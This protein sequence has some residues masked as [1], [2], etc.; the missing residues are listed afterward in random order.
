MP[1]LLAVVEQHAHQAAMLWLCR[2]RAIGEPHYSLAG[3]AKLDG[4]LDAH[5]DG[6]RIA[7]EAGWE[8]AEHELRW[9]EPGEVFA[10]ALLAFESGDPQRVQRVLSVA[11]AS[12]ELSCALVSALGWLP[13]DN[14]SDF[15][16]RFL[17][18]DDPLLR[19]VGVAASALH[20]SDPGPTLVEAI[21]DRDE[22][23]RARALR[24]AGE[25]GRVDLLSTL[26]EHLAEETVGCRFAAAWSVAL[27]A[28]EV[29]AVGALRRLVEDG[30]EKTLAAL[31]LA[32]RRT[33]IQE[34]AI[35]LPKLAAH[36]IGSSPSAP[37]PPRETGDAAR[38]AVI[39]AGVLGDAEFVPS[40]IETMQ[41]P[42]LARVAGEA[43]AMIT[44]IDIA[45][46][47]LD[48]KWPEGFSAGPTEDPEDE[49]VAMDPDENLPWPD[50]KKIAVWWAA[51]GRR[52]Q[53]G[54]RYLVGKPMTVDWLEEVLRSGY[55]RQ[56]TA[57][58]LELAI[59]RPGKPLF[60]VRAPGFR[61]QKWLGLRS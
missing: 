27:M 52:F 37:P 44:G 50:A 36:G 25:L 57:A 49:N 13:W 40:L 14:A 15:V 28:G 8:V 4:Q 1:C 3:L 45:F 2:G 59:R 21:E 46:Q 61:Q 24:A 33:E 35:W 58:A 43:V 34:A 9:Q 42:A 32:L 11:A 6:L 12:C 26:R 10:A 20:R 30:G 48:G 5:L 16:A 54:T 38:S 17:A 22:S 51:R 19:R 56:R 23:L 60:E 47:G 53:R 7:G 39:G 29:D 41:A 18:S 31:Q 55:Q